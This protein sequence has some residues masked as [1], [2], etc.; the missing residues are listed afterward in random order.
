[1]PYTVGLGAAAQAFLSAGFAFHFVVALV[2]LVII[3]G[4]S[5]SLLQDDKDKDD[6]PTPIPGLS[7]FAIYPFFRQRFDFL[8]RAFH[9]TGQ[10]VFQFYL[11]RVRFF[12]SCSHKKKRIS[13]FISFVFRVLAHSHR[14]LRRI[15]ETDVLFNQGF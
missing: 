1:M 4:V 11:L 13:V 6:A 9:E 3:L 7:L 14:R 10:S 12:L 2:A 5:S 8:N 15:C